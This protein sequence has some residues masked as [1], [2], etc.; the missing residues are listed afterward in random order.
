MTYSDHNNLLLSTT[1]C[2]EL[3]C[4][5]D[6]S[7]P[8]MISSI[9]LLRSTVSH[10]DR[11]HPM[12]YDQLFPIMMNYAPIYLTDILCSTMMPYY[13]LQFYIVMKLMLTIQLECLEV[14]HKK[15]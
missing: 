11:L 14:S 4:F 7:H 12:I 1:V 8:T 3:R 9:L 15:F 10:C 6:S 13:G 2:Y 5:N